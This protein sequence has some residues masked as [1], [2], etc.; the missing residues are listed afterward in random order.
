MYHKNGSFFVGNFMQGVANGD[1]FYIKKDG[2][3]YR[4]RMINNVADD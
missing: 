4:G 2:S 1:G 3:Y